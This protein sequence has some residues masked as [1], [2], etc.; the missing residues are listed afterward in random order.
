MKTRWSAICLTL[1]ASAATASAQIH[2]ITGRPSPKSTTGYSAGLF[3]LGNNGGIERVAGLVGPDGVE[4]ISVSPELRKAVL[5]T[6][7]RL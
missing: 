1:I 6:K 5:A 2:L 7:S 4:W 3:R